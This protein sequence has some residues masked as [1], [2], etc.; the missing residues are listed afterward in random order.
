MHTKQLKISV[1]FVII[2]L[3][4]TA[5]SGCMDDDNIKEVKGFDMNDIGEIESERNM[6]ATPVVAS[7]A[8]AFYA[9]IG[10]PVAEYYVDNDTMVA[11]LLVQ[12]HDDPADPVTRFQQ[13]YPFSNK[14]L[15]KDGTPE[16]VSLEIVDA[17]WEKSD[18][19]VLIEDSEM[20]YGLGVAAT[21]LA[22][23]L[24]IP[25]LV[26]N[27]TNNVRDLLDDL[28]VKYTFLCGDLEGHEQ[29]WRFTEENDITEF[30]IDFVKNRFGSV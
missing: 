26:T 17:V 11:P 23:Y 24:N 22:S 20:G 7:D 19:V 12:N 25:V 14:F 3:V 4:S 30:L 21:P 1:F 8:N 6:G 13:L 9:L 16:N 5:F 18:A 29:T 15:I 2:I 10:T 28:E 27:D